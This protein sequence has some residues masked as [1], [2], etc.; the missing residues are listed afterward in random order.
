MIIIAGP[1]VVENEKMIFEIAEHLCMLKEKYNFQLIFK[2]SY[3]KANRSSLNSF[4]GI[5]DLNALKILG[6]V[7][8]KFNIPVITDVHD[9]SEVAIAVDFVDY[10]QIPAFLCRQTELLL[11]AGK[12]GKTVNIKKG[13][14]MSPESMQM[15]VE[16]ARSPKYSEIWLTERGSIFGYNDLIVDFTSIPR[17][18]KI[19]DK[20][21]VDCTHSVQKPNTGLTT[22]GDPSMIETIAKAASA[23]GADGLF[24]EVHPDPKNAMSDAASMLQI[25]Q[26]EDIIYKCLSITNAINK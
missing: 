1:C 12:T 8:N 19:C 20:V 5:V 2:A 24:F 21:I 22:G 9:K 14:W 17:M 23:V 18:K 26:L 16:K 11:E 3:K 4:T 10:L 7:K 25:N 6:Q 13:Q 15:A